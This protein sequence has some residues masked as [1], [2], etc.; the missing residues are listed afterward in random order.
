M[1]IPVV[2]V[3]STPAEAA[4]GSPHSSALEQ[5]SGLTL[6]FS[7]F[8]LALL[9]SEWQCVPVGD[10]LGIFRTTLVSWEDS[11]VVFDSEGT[12]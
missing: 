2:C 7:L 1:V 9:G 3:V 6:T 10:W 12:E 5:Q 4:L 11:P 8:L